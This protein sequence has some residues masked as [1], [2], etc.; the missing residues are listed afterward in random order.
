MRLVVLCVFAFLAAATRT[1][2]ACSIE[3]KTGQTGICVEKDGNCQCTCVDNAAQGTAQVR[4]LLHDM[5]ASEEAAEKAARLYEEHIKKGD[6]DFSFS[7]EDGGK[8]FKIQV[9]ADGSAGA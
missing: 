3:C 7:V 9:R 6:R 4:R 5:Q 1:D 2:G 8:T